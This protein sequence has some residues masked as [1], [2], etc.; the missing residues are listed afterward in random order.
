MRSRKRLTGVG[1][2]M[3]FWLMIPASHEPMTPAFSRRSEGL[4][5][6]GISRTID[7]SVVKLSENCS[8]SVTSATSVANSLGLVGKLQRQTIDGLMLAWL[9]EAC[10][11]GKL[12]SRS[13]CSNC[14]LHMSTTSST[15]HLEGIT[16]PVPEQFEPSLAICDLEA[17]R[18]EYVCEMRDQRFD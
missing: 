6:Q 2:R 14:H 8:S 1:C 10:L 15:F 7:S 12:T 3:Y 11:T 13:F 4:S 5:S 17:R 9:V 18:L 16:S